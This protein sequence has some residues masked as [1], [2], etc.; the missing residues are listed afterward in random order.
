MPDL[1][2]RI[3]RY[4]NRPPEWTYY[5]RK[6]TGV[7]SDVYIYELRRHRDGREEIRSRDGTWTPLPEA[8]F[9]R[10]PCFEAYHKRLFDTSVPCE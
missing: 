2:Q 4:M 7:C 6:S 5:N 1:I 10:L 3:R 8:R 9:S